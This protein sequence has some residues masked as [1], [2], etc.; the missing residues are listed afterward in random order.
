[1]L[2]LKIHFI[3]WTSLLTVFKQPYCRNDV[4]SCDV[5]AT[6]LNYY[7]APRCHHFMKNF[8]ALLVTFYGLQCQN[9]LSVTSGGSRI[10]PRRGR[11]LS[12]G[13]ANIR[14]CQ[15][16]PKTAWN[17]KNLDPQGGRASKILLCRSATGNGCYCNHTTLMAAT[18]L[19]RNM[20]RNR[21]W[22]GV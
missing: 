2:S 5:H 20:Y 22:S 6:C 21:L 11:Q 7:L 17:W 13:G 4:I 12:R 10:S 14:F 15:I 18:I 8:T 3:H 19:F 9:V 1:M 16:F